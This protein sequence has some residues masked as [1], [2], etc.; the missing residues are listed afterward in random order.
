MAKT[1]S[2]VSGVSKSKTAAPKVVRTAPPKADAPTALYEVLTPFKFRDTIVKPPSWIEMTEAEAAEYQD[3]GVL[4]T[5]PGE[6]PGAGVEDPGA[7]G[8]AA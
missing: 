3:A 7:A 1:K 2:K 6:V 8:A 5:E 4:G